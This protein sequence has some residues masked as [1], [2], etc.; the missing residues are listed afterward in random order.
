MTTDSLGTRVRGPLFRLSATQGTIGRKV[1][2]VPGDRRSSKF[3]I[4]TESVLVVNVV[5]FIDGPDRP[6]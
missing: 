3:L 4:W 2:T 5:N 6:D 1:G